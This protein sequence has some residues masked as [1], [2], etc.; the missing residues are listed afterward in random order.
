MRTSLLS[1]DC[2]ILEHFRANFYAS[3]EFGEP[4]SVDFFASADCTGHPTVTGSRDLAISRSEKNM[5]KKVA[6]Y[7]CDSA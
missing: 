5:N 6:N 4:F 3:F 7:I 1:D 2:S